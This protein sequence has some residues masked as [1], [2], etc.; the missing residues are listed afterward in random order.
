MTYL[1]RID[2]EQASPSQTSPLTSLY[3]G[4]RLRAGPAAKAADM[5]NG[6][7]PEDP[8]APSNIGAPR[9]WRAPREEGHGSF[10]LIEKDPH[11]AGTIREDDIGNTGVWRLAMQ[12]L[13]DY[14]A[15]RRSRPQ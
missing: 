14:L 7:K 6:R 2:G 13:R 4:V 10:S 11:A 9:R 5:E 1:A 15:G 8:L 3:R 12:V